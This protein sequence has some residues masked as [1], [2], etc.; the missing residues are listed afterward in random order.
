MNF[1]FLLLV[2]VVV[3]CNW[4]D[5]WISL[6]ENSNCT[7][8]STGTDESILTIPEFPVTALD[9]VLATLSWTGYLPEDLHVVCSKGYCDD[10]IAVHEDKIEIRSSSINIDFESD[11]T[12]K[13]IILDILYQQTSYDNC[14]PEADGSFPCKVVANVSLCEVDISYFRS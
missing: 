13:E 6:L 10:I 3:N 4:N 11:P 7:L 1:Y 9:S 5:P 8:E 12:D 14:L 2:A